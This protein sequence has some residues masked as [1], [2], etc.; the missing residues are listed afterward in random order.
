MPEIL[1]N[2][3]KTVLVIGSPIVLI[4]LAVRSWKTPD[5]DDSH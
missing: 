3:L 2:L 4:L 1:E 5:A